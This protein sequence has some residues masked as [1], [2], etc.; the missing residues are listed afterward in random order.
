MTDPLRRDPVEFLRTLKKMAS[1]TSWQKTMLFASRGRMIGFHLGVDHYNTILFS[2]ALWGRALEIIRVIRGME[3]DRV[4]P[5]GITFYYICNGMANADHG[6]T[7][8][9]NN[10]FRLQGLQHWRV[11][12]NALQACIDRGFDATDTMY[13]STIVTCTIPTMNHWQKALSVLAMMRDEDRKPHPQMIKFLHLCL[14]RNERPREAV[15]LLQYAHEQKVSGYE[16]STPEPDVFA[17]LPPEPTDP[18]KLDEVPE[19]LSERSLILPSTSVPRDAEEIFR[20]RVYRQLWYKW[21]AVANK[22]RPTAAL[23]KRQLAPKFSPT[24]IPGFFRK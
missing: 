8:D 21:H 17:L 24:G 16:S 18:V 5:N 15:R 10:N 3:E 23:R 4:K 9:Y 12:I 7:F 14:L 13:N 6:Y 19:Y 2:Q 11:A 20:P 22:Y 1:T